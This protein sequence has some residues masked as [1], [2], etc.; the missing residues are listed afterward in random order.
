MSAD[1]IKQLLTALKTCS[2]CAYR[3]SVPGSGWSQWGHFDREKV[4]KAITAADAHLRT[5]PDTPTVDLD[6]IAKLERENAKLNEMS[7][8][9]DALR[10]LL[11]E[12]LTRIAVA[13]KGE[14][15]PL[16][17]RGWHDLPELVTAMME[18]HAEQRTQAN[19]DAL[20]RAAVLLD[21]ANIAMFDMYA[22]EI[23]EMKV[24]T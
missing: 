8:E 15:P 22:G 10:D 2:E 23:R 5:V 9:D 7:E 1:L 13:L 11:S 6:R 19:N 3:E 24:P 16:T 21:G 4:A 18:K 17:L 12:K 14:P 20:E